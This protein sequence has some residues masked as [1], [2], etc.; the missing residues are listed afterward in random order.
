[1]GQKLNRSS[2]L[3]EPAKSQ[4]IGVLTAAKSAKI[5]VFASIQNRGAPR[6]P[7]VQRIALLEEVPKQQRI[8]YL[9]ARQKTTA[10]VF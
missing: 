3:T 6:F 1:V 10:V 7:K 5:G 9:N 2:V 4:R 8:N